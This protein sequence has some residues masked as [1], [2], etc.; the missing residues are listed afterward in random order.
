MLKDLSLGSLA[1]VKLETIRR[2]VLS[3]QFGNVSNV[4]A[5]EC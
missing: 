2:Q 3:Q 4:S 1:S 5:L